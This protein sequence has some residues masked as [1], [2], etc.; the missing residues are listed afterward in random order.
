MSAFYGT[1]SPERSVFSLGKEEKSGKKVAS[2]T[3]CCR[4][5]AVFPV[6]GLSSLCALVFRKKLKKKSTP[7]GQGVEIAVEPE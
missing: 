2:A 5:N 7:F 1:E 3:V 4:M 6:F